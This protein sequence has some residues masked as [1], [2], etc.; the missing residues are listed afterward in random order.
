MKKQ[1]NIH[2]NTHHKPYLLV[3][4]FILFLVF[5]LPLNAQ[6]TIFSMNQDGVTYPNNSIDIRYY[7]RFENGEKIDFGTKKEANLNLRGKGKARLYIDLSN[8]QFDKNYKRADRKLE[9]IVQRHYISWGK[10]LELATRFPL[11]I[12]KDTYKIS[13]AFD[14]EDNGAGQ[15][16]VQLGIA[17][18]NKRKDA[19]VAFNFFRSYR[20]KGLGATA[21][22]PED[23]AFQD[24][25]NN[26]NLNNARKFLVGFPNGSHSSKVKQY[27]KDQDNLEWN[28]A[29]KANTITAFERYKRLFATDGRYLAQCKQKIRRIR[30]LER[31]ADKEKKKPKKPEKDLTEKGG[32]VV[33]NEA[34]VKEREVWNTLDMNN[35]AALESFVANFPTSNFISEAKEQIARLTEPSIRYEKIDEQTFQVE[36]EAHQPSFDPLS[37]YRERYNLELDTNQ[38]QAKKSFL[39]KIIEPGQYVLRLLDGFGREILVD[40]NNLLSATIGEITDQ[41]LQLMISGGVPPYT[42]NLRNEA[43]K[44]EEHHFA[45]THDSIFWVEHSQLKASGLQ[46]KYV[47]TVGDSRKEFFVAVGEPLDIVPASLGYLPFVLVAILALAV[48]VWWFIRKRLYNPKTVFDA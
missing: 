41:G 18:R 26:H 43:D 24:F 11:V 30:A 23:I 19:K 36:V 21:L 44:Q 13:V 45:N 16:G 34:D 12:D 39:V 7:V 20:I 8:L 28:N 22:S 33:E 1:W 17:K 32:D 2:N 37:L 40:L 9:V 46:G 6:R 38:W 10:G 42:V 48:G 35:K 27:I 5:S 47:L 14:V 31:I 25:M 29:V 3:L 15:I 4:G